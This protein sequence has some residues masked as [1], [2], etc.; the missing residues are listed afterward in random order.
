MLDTSLVKRP[1]PSGVCD[2]DRSGAFP[3]PRACWN[4]GRFWIEELGLRLCSY[5]LGDVLG[6]LKRERYTIERLDW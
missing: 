4:R 5:H 1:A 3:N 6:L 2:V